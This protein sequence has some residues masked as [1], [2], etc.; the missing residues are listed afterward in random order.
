MGGFAWEPTEEYLEGANVTRLMRRHGISDYR[1]LVRRS[2]D[3]IEW[4]WNAVVEDLCI[5]F[6]VPYDE[7]LDASGG[8]QWP[9]WFSGGRVNL[10]YNCVDRHAHSAESS[11]RDAIVWEGEDGDVRTISYAALDAE[12]NRVANGIEQLGI[13]EGDTVGVYMPMV[14]EAVIAAYACA[15]IGAI[16]LPIFSGFGAPA[17]ATR[18]NDASVKLLFTADGFFR[19]GARVPMKEVADEA[20]AAS[21]SVEHV[22]VYRRFAGTEGGAPEFHMGPRDVSWGSAFEGQETE[23]RAAE[24]DPETPLMIAYTSGTTG[25]PKGSVHVHG[26]FLVKIAE[27]AAY[28]ADVKAGDVLYWVT[29][30]GWIMGPWEMVGTHAAGATV[31]MYEGAPN[32]PNED[33]LWEMCARHRVTILG[34]SPTLVR[35]LMPAGEEAVRKHDLSRLRILASTGEAWNPEPYRWFSEVV[36][37]GRLPV[38][39]I[40]GGTEVGACFLGPA[41][42]IPTK[43]CSLGMPALG[44]AMDVRDPEGNSCRPG[45]VGELV[46]TKPWP[47]QTRGFWGSPERYLATYWSRWPDT[48]VHGDWASVDEDGY[49]F[50]HGRSDDT[51]NIAGK[52]IGPAEFESAAVD[53]PLV[54]ECAAVGVPDAVK[55]EAVWCFCILT[56]GTEGSEGLAAQIKKMITDDLGKAFK[57][58]QVRFVD[59]L[60][61]TRSAKILRRAIRARVLGEDP[62]DLSSLENPAALDSIDRSLA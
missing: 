26:G 40:S 35:A 17:V 29:D 22:V 59:Q 19:R 18:L 51:L 16:Y 23:R 61:K 41:P 2:T 4:F 8:P 1:E 13:R 33:R 57:P 31:F 6:F 7:V 14:P 54:V 42:V 38:I 32:Y 43:S 46:C 47:A 50:L 24:L 30:M 20:V 10:T 34:I 53:H 45:E 27:E 37:G 48:W 62:G 39:N 11:G 44:M 56:P 36:G 15:K 3:D 9:K 58:A 28:Q 12:V 21:P 60:P 52:R 55:G 5:H 25:K 49:W